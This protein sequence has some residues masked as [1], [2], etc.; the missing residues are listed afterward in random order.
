LLEDMQNSS[1]ESCT[2]KG[3]PESFLLGERL[4]PLKQSAINSRLTKQMVSP[5]EKPPHD[6]CA[7]SIETASADE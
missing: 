7:L 5:W 1:V 6:K 3:A 2:M 4:R